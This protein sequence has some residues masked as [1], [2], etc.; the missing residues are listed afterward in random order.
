MSA[1]TEGWA[2]DDG[3]DT[4][5]GEPVDSFSHDP[6]WYAV[7]PDTEYARPYGRA[8]RLAKAWSEAL[9]KLTG[10]DAVKVRPIQGSDGRSVLHA[11]VD[12]A[13]AA[14]LMEQ[15]TEWLKERCGGRCWAALVIVPIVVVAVGR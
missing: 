7:R 6:D 3:E 14:E 10:S 11:Y 9:R 8:L 1:N 4:E 13:E 2:D 5:Q 12:E 15:F